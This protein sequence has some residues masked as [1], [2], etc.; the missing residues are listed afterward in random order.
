VN[1]TIAVVLVALIAGL[2]AIGLV[3]GE[4]SSSSASGGASAAAEPSIASIANQVERI[5]QLRF[6]HLPPGRRVTNATARRDAL[7]ELDRELPPRKLAQS[8]QMLKLLHL[9]PQSASLRSL[10]GKAFGNEVGGYYDPRTGKLSVVG[11][12][13]GLLREIT[14]AHEL[15]HALE[16]QHFDLGK[17]GGGGVL[18]D[19]SVADTAVREGSAT[20]VM[21]DY[22]IFKQTGGLKVPE[23]LR[24]RVLGA[25]DDASV[26][27]SSGLPRYVR[28]SLVFPYPA[29]ARLID[30][31]QRRGG[32]A[33]V[34]RLYGADAPKSSEQIMHP[35]KFHDPPK[36]V[37]IPGVGAQLRGTVGEFD[38]EQ[39]LR[40]ENGAARS[41]RAAAGWGGG[42][43]A[44]FPDRL[45]LRWT[46]DTP[47]DTA[48]AWSALRRTA[49][50]LHGRASRSGALTTLTIPR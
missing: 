39:L 15:T 40:D 16:D 46:W 23:Q 24:Q 7:D 18:D 3:T 41:R 19:R 22:A 37:S 50:A 4:K 49:R 12:G 2:A 35:S 8:E 36:R 34:N 20:I 9:I 27:S 32:W 11:G 31:V 21:V 6:D 5:R 13:G 28:E 25:L 42:S 33:A 48:E 38:T 44:L 30:R 1:G 14:L 45:V 17:D 43:Y 10:L 26:P 29:G 47:T